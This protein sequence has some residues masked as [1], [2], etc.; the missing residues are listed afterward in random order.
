MSLYEI[1]TTHNDTECLRN[2]DE[3][4]ARGNLDKFLLGCE[5]GIHTSWATIGSSQRKRCAQDHPRIHAQSSHDCQSV[6]NDARTRQGDPFHALEW[7]ILA[8]SELLIN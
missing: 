6:K 5:S 7:I 4:V 2:L 3:L 8:Y 1:E